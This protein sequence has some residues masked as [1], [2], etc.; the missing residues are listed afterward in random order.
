MVRT[1]PN[2]PF[3][4]RARR[5]YLPTVR[6][7]ALALPLAAAL[8]A[9][10]LATAPASAAPARELRRDGNHFPASV[11]TTVP[12]GGSST[13][14]SPTIPKDT[15]TLVVELVAQANATQPQVEVFD[16]LASVLG[17]MTKGKRLLTCIMLYNALVTAPQLED[18]YNTPVTFQAN[19]AISALAALVGCI[20]LAGLGTSTQPT[21]TVGAPATAPAARAV[22]ERG[23]LQACA[24]DQVGVPGT[25]EQSDGTWT[26]AL[27]GAIK[28][29]RNKLRIGC[30]T[31]S[32]KTV[33]KIRAATKG[34]PLRKVTGKRPR[35]S[36]VSP[37][38][39][40]AS[41]PTTV[42]FRLP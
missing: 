28:K 2:G 42:T 24:R 31:K 23:K 7:T 22:A 6:R 1:G 20:H 38:D 25:L 34:V 29:A 13:I 21:P 30:R 33:L 19:E 12:A 8:V 3:R 35:L 10:A 17:K 39:A 37:A 5:A 32:G 15:K 14:T 36:L 41:A 26:L 18:D 27:D 40:A 11:D 9:T 16:K 4:R